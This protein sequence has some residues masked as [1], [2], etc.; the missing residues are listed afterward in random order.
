MNNQTY[1][2]KVK[3]ANR[4]KIADKIDELP[5]C[6]VRSVVI[7]D[8]MAVITVYFLDSSK[9]PYVDYLVARLNK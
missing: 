1:T 8:N 6:D 3:I 9:L 5:E 7:K 2:Y 4:L